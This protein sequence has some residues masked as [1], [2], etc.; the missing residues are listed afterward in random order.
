[1]DGTVLRRMQGPISYE[2]WTEL[3]SVSVLA[4]LRQLPRIYAA[5]TPSESGTLGSADSNSVVA[6]ISTFGPIVSWLFPDIRNPGNGLNIFQTQFH[7][8]Q[9]TER[10]S[11]IHG[12]ELTNEVCGEQRLGMAGRRQVERH[13]VRVR[14]PRGIEIDR[15]FHTRPFRLRHRWVGAKQ[16]VESQTSPPRDRTPA[17]NANQPRNLLMHREAS[18]EITNIEKDAQAR[19]EPIQSQFPS[20][21]IA[22]VGSSS[23][24]VVLERG[25]L[26]FG[27][28][29][30][31][32]S[33]RVKCLCNV[34]VDTQ[35]F[36]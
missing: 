26:R 23:V 31:P 16:I 7:G 25:N 34:I 6:G 11:M 14:I 21:N 27:V 8:H 5:V 36:V 24:V 13:K 17:F 28:G 22:R 9:Q 3:E 4:V 32:A 10:R 2:C 1:M 15:R 33:S 30:H 35:C 12:K 18:Q 29:G 20:R 19:S